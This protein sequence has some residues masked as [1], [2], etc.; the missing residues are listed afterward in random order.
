MLHVPHGE[1]QGDLNA[2]SRRIIGI[3]AGEEDILDRKSR[4]GHSC[5]E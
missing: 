5:L 2:D 3:R 1:E 4:R